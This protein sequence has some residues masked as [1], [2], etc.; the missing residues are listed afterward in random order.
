MR[1]ETEYRPKPMVEIGGK[2]LLWH[3]MKQYTHF[4]YNNFVLALG[5]KGNDIK[6]FFT[7][8]ELYIS[9][10]RINTSTGTTEIID[11]Y[12][13][14]DFIIT[15]IDTG[16]NTLTGERVLR[17]KRYIKSDIFMLT[18]GDGLSDVDIHK[19]VAFHKKQKTIGTITGVNPHSRFGL[20]NVNK[21]NIITDFKQKPKLHDYV[22][23]G[24]MVFNQEFFNYIENGDMIEEALIRLMMKNQLSLYSHKD[25]WFAIDTIRDLE[26]ANQLWKK[27]G[28]PWAVW[29]KNDHK[30]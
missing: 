9:N 23:G 10:F 19:L 15:F 18:Y 3:I 2:P 28:R 26:E 21:K 11:R 25:F 27:G 24:F 6:E 4:D 22:N 14:D 8:Q 20:I 29:G 7:K 1:E 13:E 16:Q 5:Y 17:L 12:K 30:K